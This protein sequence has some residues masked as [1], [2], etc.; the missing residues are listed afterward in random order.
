MVDCR[1]KRK[2]NTPQRLDAFPLPPAHRLTRGSIALIPLPDL[3][4][5]NAHGWTATRTARGDAAVVS[6][7]PRVELY[8]RSLA[9]S[10]GRDQQEAVL[11]T[12]NGLA[13]AGR[14]AGVEVTVC[15]ECVCPSLTAAET[16]VGERLLRRYESFEGWADEADRDLVGFEERDTTSLV[17]DTEITGIVFPRLTLAEYRGSDLAFVAPSRNGVDTTSVLDRLEDY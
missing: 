2:E 4:L 8:L 17:T 10:E 14:I 7:P 12:L 5:R 16:D 13:E 1:E 9:P 3:Y 15:G 11:Q 6:E